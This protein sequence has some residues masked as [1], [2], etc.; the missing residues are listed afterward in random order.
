MNLTQKT[1][2]IVPL[3]EIKGHYPAL[4]LPPSTRS[5][6][7]RGPAVSPKMDFQFSTPS[8]FEPVYSIL[9]ELNSTLNKH[10]LDGKTSSLYFR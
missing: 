6:E 2:N 3:S 1:A 9:L 5:R 4:E 8:P 7:E 10:N